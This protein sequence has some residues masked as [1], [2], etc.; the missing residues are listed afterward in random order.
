MINKKLNKMQMERLATCT[1][2]RLPHVLKNIQLRKIIA[3]AD[4]IRFPIFVFFG[5]FLGLRISEVM[6]LRWEDIDINDC[7]VRILDAKNTRRFKS[8]YGKD[9]IVPIEKCFIPF[10]KQWKSMNPD[11]EYV[12]PFKNKNSRQGYKNQ[13]VKSMVRKFQHKMSICLREL[14]FD[15]VDYYQNDGKP[16]YKYHTHTFRHIAGCNLRRRGMPLE[17]IRDFLGHEK[18]ET[19]LVYAEL[20]KEDLKE[21]LHVA[22]NYPKNSSKLT[23]EATPAIEIIPDKES[24]KIMNE[25]LKMMLELHV[26]NGGG[27][28]NG[29]LL[30]QEIRTGIR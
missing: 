21:S 8:G 7:I 9:R 10:I 24:L 11:E 29:N 14:K 16:R 27:N 3:V 17:D 4:D 30:K 23:R 25:N 13:I 20:T 2:K 12:I 1:K 19:T 22:Y 15:Q 26:N 18:I 6:K 28:W 5:I